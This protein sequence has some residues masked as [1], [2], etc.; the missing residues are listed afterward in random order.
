MATSRKRTLRVG[1]DVR[2]LSEELGATVKEGK[3]TAARGK[4]FVEVGRL[5]KEIVVGDTTPEAEVKALAGKSVGVVLAGRTIVGERFVLHPLVPLWLR[6]F[7]DAPDTRLW[8]VHSEPAAFLRWEG[9]LAEVGDPI[10]RVDLLPG[11]QSGPA[12]PLPRAVTGTPRSFARRSTEATSTVLAGCTT[13]S[14]S[15]GVTVSAS[16]CA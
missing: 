6:P 7:V 9:P 4:Y 11:G 12:V 16:S 1:V 8:L 10:V 2:K 14:G 3:V 5:K 13:A 15:C